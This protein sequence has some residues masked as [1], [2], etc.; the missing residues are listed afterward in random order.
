MTRRQRGTAFALSVGR[1]EHYF[2]K[3]SPY[4]G[5]GELT[6]ELLSTDTLDVIRSSLSRL[7]RVLP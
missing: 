5:A 3:I 6:T 2:D 4:R 1:N 7:G